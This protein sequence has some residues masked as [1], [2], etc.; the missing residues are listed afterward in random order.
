MLSSNNSCPILVSLLLIS[1]QQEEFIEEALQSALAQDYAHLQIVVSDDASEDGTWEIINKVVASYGADHQVVVRR[2]EINKGLAGNFNEGI[3]ACSGELIVVQAGDDISEK[4]RVSS[5]VR[6]WINLNKEPDMLYSNVKWM[7]KDGSVSKVDQHHP[8]IPDVGEIKKGAYFI[9]G[10]MSAA[11]TRRL[12]QKFG[13]L[14]EAVRTEDYV[15]TFRAL[16]SGGVAFESAALLRYRQ[17][18]ASEMAMRR[19]MSREHHRLLVYSAAKVAEAEDRYRSWV[20]SR[21]PGIIYRMKLMKAVSSARLS[22]LSISGSLGCSFICSFVALIT[23]SPTT[24]LT[25]LK[26]DIVQR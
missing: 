22:H 8:Y 7:K 15:L 23:L 19:N 20:I 25:I 21:R 13:L 12:F 17:H 14:S 4:N 1:Y 6:L 11:Y 9:A 3:K 18:P 5:L 24:F 26:R 2:N 16:I 10:G